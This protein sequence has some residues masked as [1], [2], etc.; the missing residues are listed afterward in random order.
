MATVAAPLPKVQAYKS[1]G[2]VAV[3]WGEGGAKQTTPPHSTNYSDDSYHYI[4]SAVDCKGDE[5]VVTTFGSLLTCHG[6][7]LTIGK[8]RYEM[9]V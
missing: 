6:G 4:F 3:K 2:D 8:T 5:L 9:Q 7:I 1:D